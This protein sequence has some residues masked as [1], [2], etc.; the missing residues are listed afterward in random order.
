M[1][2]TANDVSGPQATVVVSC[3]KSPVVKIGCYLVYTV[4]VAGPP[5]SLNSSQHNRSPQG[6]TRCQT[7]QYITAGLSQECVNVTS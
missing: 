6:L 5:S 2:H 3:G 7:V 4:W 1:R